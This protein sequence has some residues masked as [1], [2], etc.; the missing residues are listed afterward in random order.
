MSATQLGSMMGKELGSW[1]ET[2]S[3]L[4]LVLMSGSQLDS[5]LDSLWGSPSE[6]WLA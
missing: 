2:P 1:S 5:S 3:G 4:L 6:W